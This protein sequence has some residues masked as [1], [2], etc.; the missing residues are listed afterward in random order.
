MLLVSSG[1]RS[2]L[3]FHTC[4]VFSPRLGFRARSRNTFFSLPPLQILFLSFFL[5]LI[6]PP[7]GFHLFEGFPPLFLASACSTVHHPLTNLTPLIHGLRSVQKRDLYRKRFT[8]QPSFLRL[9]RSVRSI[10]VRHSFHD[11][12]FGESRGPLSPID[13]LRLFF[14]LVFVSGYGHFLP[15]HTVFLFLALLSSPVFFIHHHNLLSTL[16]N[17]P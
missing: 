10:S 15:L 4:F 6:T 8:M 2:E 14:L 13:I 3:F 1:A 5:P 16:L 17:H 12:L 11:F 7:A 9:F